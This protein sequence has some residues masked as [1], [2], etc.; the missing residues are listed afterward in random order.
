M[1]WGHEAR[2]RAPGGVKGQRP[3]RGPWG[4]APGRSGVLAILNALGEL[5]WTLISNPLKN[6]Y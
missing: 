5:S 3:G 2:L 1:A 4:S 6:A